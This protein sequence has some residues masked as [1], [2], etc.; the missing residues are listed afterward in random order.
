[1]Q[2]LKLKMQGVGLMREGGRNRGILRC[3]GNRVTAVEGFG[4]VQRSQRSLQLN[5]LLHSWFES[6]ENAHAVLWTNAIRSVS[7]V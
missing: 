3:E 1:M 5:S 6:W 4:T 7:D 2:E